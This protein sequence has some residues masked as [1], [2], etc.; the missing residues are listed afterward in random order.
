MVRCPG[1][2]A[3]VGCDNGLPKDSV[4]NTS[5]V[6][7]LGKAALT[8]RLGRLSRAKTALLLA[9]IDVVLGR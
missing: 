9:G 6:L 2:R 4:A 3:P 7:T 5:Q 1:E 8:D